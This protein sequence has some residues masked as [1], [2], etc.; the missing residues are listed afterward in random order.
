MLENALVFLLGF[1]AALRWSSRIPGLI[2]LCLPL[3]REDVPT[4]RNLPEVQGSNWHAET[5]TIQEHE[6]SPV[7]EI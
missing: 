7:A 6:S 1:G 4:A 3:R 5:H 2:D